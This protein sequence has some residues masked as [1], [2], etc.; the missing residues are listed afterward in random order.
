MKQV[1]QR[2]GWIAV[3]TPYWAF[4]QKE[5]PAEFRAIDTALFQDASHHWYDLYEKDRVI[6][7]KANQPRYKPTELAAVA[8]N[9][10]LYQKDNGGW[11]KNYDMLA[12]LTPEQKD[13]LIK[14]KPVLNTTFDNRTT[15]AHI[16][17]LAK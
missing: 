17:A 4:A 6:Q 10:L 7:P 9:I 15:Y 1:F 12:I 3:L 8:D 16:E 11:P 2:I 5:V 14:D 13:S